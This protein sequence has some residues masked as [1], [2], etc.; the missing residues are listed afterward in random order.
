MASF[1]YDA[2]SARGVQPLDLEVNRQL[3]FYND[4]FG[5]SRIAFTALAD[6]RPPDTLFGPCPADYA[7][8]PEQG[9]SQVLDAVRNLL[10]FALDVLTMGSIDDEVSSAYVQDLGW[11]HA[12][13]R[14][15]AGNTNN[16][17]NSS[18]NHSSSNHSSNGNSG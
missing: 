16:N 14:V 7:Q 10:L 4:I 5:W 18:S 2:V 1:V 13:P 9:R 15:F 8:V 17:I 3:T 12:M 11:Y 6:R